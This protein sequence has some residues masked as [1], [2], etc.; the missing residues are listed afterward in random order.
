MYLLYLLYTESRL[1][2]FTHKNQ[3]QILR[4]IQYNM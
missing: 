1:A 4:V 3:K 2:K